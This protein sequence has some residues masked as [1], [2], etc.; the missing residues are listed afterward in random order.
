MSMTFFHFNSIF[1]YLE[2]C[3]AIL[4]QLEHLR[5]RRHRRSRRQDPIR[6]CRHRRLRRQRRFTNTGVW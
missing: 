6:R 2:L 4:F 3:N 1:A 5:H